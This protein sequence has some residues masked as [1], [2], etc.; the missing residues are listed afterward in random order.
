MTNRS[1]A[2]G[3]AAESAI[4]AYLKDCGWPHVE[5]RTLNG[6]ADRGDIAGIP[7]VVIE[8]KNVKTITLG[9]FVDEANK[10]R[11]N[12]GADVGAAW[13]KRRGKGSPADWYVVMDGETFAG[14]LRAAGYGPNRGAA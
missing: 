3:T 14:L 9:T 10:E 8:S 2:K 4:V 11:D 7:G 1:K 5:R 12:A 13:V 6:S